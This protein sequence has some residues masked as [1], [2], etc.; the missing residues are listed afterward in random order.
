ML[1]AR[2]ILMVSRVPLLPLSAKSVVPVLP[3][4]EDIPLHRIPKLSFKQSSQLEELSALEITENRH[5][6]LK[7]ALVHQFIQTGKYGHVNFH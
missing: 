7:A 6:H 5:S 1:L 2:L 3:I 4:D